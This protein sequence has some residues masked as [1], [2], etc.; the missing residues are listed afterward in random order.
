MPGEQ[1]LQEARRREEGAGADGHEGQVRALHAGQGRW[2][3]EIIQFASFILAL[4][5]TLFEI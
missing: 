5:S 4:L 3:R 1:G 2:R